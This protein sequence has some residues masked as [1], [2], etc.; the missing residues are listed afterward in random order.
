[1]VQMMLCGTTLK[2][3]FACDLLS[4]QLFPQLTPQ[5]PDVK[6]VN[7]PSHSLSQSLTG[8]LPYRA[9]DYYYVRSLSLLYL[10]G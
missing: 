1:M 6:L 10:S 4:N 7:F 9:L 2:P 3:K 5:N 8:L